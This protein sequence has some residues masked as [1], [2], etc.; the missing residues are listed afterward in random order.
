MS[1]IA[2]LVVMYPLILWVAL[3]N[4]IDRATKA[5][6][7]G[8]YFGQCSELCGLN[9]AYMPITVKVVSQEAYDAWMAKAKTGEYLLSQA[10]AASGPLKV[11]ANN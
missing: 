3:H 2:L 5:E 8:I 4:I 11:A 1:M 6:R 7:E 10:P 9:H